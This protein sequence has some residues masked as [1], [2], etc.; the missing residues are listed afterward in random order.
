[1][2]KN[3]PEVTP[4]HLGKPVTR[5]VPRVRDDFYRDFFPKLFQNEKNE[6]GSQTSGFDACLSDIYPHN[7]ARLR[8]PKA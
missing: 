1:M 5:T 8:D 3:L 4:K 2:C 6:K 7:M